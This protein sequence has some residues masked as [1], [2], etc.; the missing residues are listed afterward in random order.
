[1][2]KMQQAHAEQIA[3]VLRRLFPRLNYSCQSYLIAP[4]G[5]PLVWIPSEEIAKGFFDEEEE[6]DDDDDDEEGRNLLS[7]I[8]R[9]MIESGVFSQAESFL[10]PTGY[11]AVSFLLPPGCNQALVV[12]V[13]ELTLVKQWQQQKSKEAKEAFVGKVLEGIGLGLMGVGVGMVV[14]NLAA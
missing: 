3:V 6:D 14:R 8:S 10:L 4:F 13:G 1:M 11:G 5:T 2:D 7:R 9:Q 12:L